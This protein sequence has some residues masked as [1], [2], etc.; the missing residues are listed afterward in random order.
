[1]KERSVIRALTQLLSSKSSPVRA[2]LLEETTKVVD[3]LETVDVGW[4]SEIAIHDGRKE[5]RISR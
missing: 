3:C 1:M 5:L 4:L 2:E